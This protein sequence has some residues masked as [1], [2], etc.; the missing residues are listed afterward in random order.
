MAGSRR[1]RRI[2]RARAAKAGSDPTGA[3]GLEP[4]TSGVTGR[5]S[6]RVAPPSR[7]ASA[8]VAMLAP[9]TSE[10]GLRRQRGNNGNARRSF[11]F[12]RAF[13][14]SRVTAQPWAVSEPGRT[15]ANTAPSRQA[16]GHWFEPSTAHLERPWQR[17]FSLRSVTVAERAVLARRGADRD[18]DSSRIGRRLHSPP[19]SRLRQGS[20]GEGTTCRTPV[21]IGGSA[22]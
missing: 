4:A 8:L 13:A 11:T 3:S 16:G 7:R 9:P 6:C 19:S 15:G 22:G 21:G 10:L 18:V 2:Q 5:R 20:P 17:A 14:R 12:A 1:L